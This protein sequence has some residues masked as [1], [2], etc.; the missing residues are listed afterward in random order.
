MQPDRSHAHSL[1]AKLRSFIRSKHGSIL[2]MFAVV[3]MV[4]LAAG[5]SGVDVSLAI[6]AKQGLQNSL[7]AAVLA[8]ATT[9]NDNRIEVAKE[10]FDAN[11]KPRV[12]AAVSRTFSDANSTINGKASVNVKTYFLGFA[13]LDTLSV[14]A[15]SAARYSESSEPGP[16]I[17][18]MDK[19]ASPGFKAN[20]SGK[21]DAPDCQMDVHSKSRN[22][23]YIDSNHIKLDKMCVAGTVAGN[24]VRD[25]DNLDSNC[26]VADDPYKAS[27]PAVPNDVVS[28]K[29][30]VSWGDMPSSNGNNI[31]M[32]FKPGTYCYF[33]NINGNVKKVVF[34][35]GNYYF[36]GINTFNSKEVEFGAGNYVFDG[37]TVQMNGSV[38]NVKM[39]AGLYVVKNGGTIRFDNQDVTGTDVSI[40]LADQHSRFI[41]AQG[42]TKA[43]L[44]APTT[45]PYA[46]MA[47][48]EKPGLNPSGTYNLDGRLDLEGLVYLPS[49][50]I[51]FNGNGKMSGNNLSLVFHRLSLDGKIDIKAGSLLGG[52][53]KERNAYL[54]K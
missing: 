16:C 5:G 7:D 49:R 18:V 39:G 6:L 46:G 10:V 11:Y 1:R 3:G 9:E 45:G 27:V 47:I 48:F 34:K 21:I 12:D 23:A 24:R 22:A 31:T 8:A 28:K 25:Y 30:C 37:V 33:P 13:G 32:E 17:L 53:S 35:P 26:S 36:T 38:H 51:H 20:G 44:T 43:K 52:T 41:T 40:Y 19:N 50:N 42:S 29:S 2:P 4:T 14:G 15:E 54:M